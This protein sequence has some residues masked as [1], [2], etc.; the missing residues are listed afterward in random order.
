MARYYMEKEEGN[1]ILVIA[2]DDTGVFCLHIEEGSIG[3][4]R[5]VNPVT[6]ICLAPAD[7]EMVSTTDEKFLEFMRL[8][9]RGS[10]TTSEPTEIETI[11]GSA[12]EVLEGFRESLD[13]PG[14]GVYYSRGDPRYG[15]GRERE[16]ME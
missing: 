15:Q 11:E 2:Q 6:W 1:V 7:A 5:A 3:Q 16:W 13:A 10:Y 9:E 14:G 12:I 4:V 8:W